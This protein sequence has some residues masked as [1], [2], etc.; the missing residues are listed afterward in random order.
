MNLSFSDL[1][2]PIGLLV[3]AVITLALAPGQQREGPPAAVEPTMTFKPDLAFPKEAEEASL[4]A[5][6]W[7]KVL[8]GR[9]GVPGKTEILKRDPEMAFMFDDAARRWAMQCRYSP[10]KD[11]VGNPVEVWVSIPINFK[12]QDFQPPKLIQLAA[13]EY[14]EEARSLGMEGWVG[15]AVFVDEMGNALNAKSVIVARE[16]PYYKLFDDAAKA[17]AKKSEYSAAIYK[18]KPTNGWCFVKVVF[19]F[20]ER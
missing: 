1:R 6:L 19:A 18:N 11:S 7:V 15:I 5:K 3:F 2:K 8:I 10:A 9:D 20:P 13:P 16:P 14:P 17:A 4:T 12:M